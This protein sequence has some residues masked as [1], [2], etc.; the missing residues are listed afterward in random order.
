[1]SDPETK[2]F[3]P[4]ALASISTGIMLMENGFSAIHEAAE[5]LLGH[6][7]WTHELPDCWPRMR[8]CVLEQ[9]PDMP[10]EKPADFRKLA[11]EIKARYGD[12]VE[13]KRG[14]YERS[15]GPIDTFIAQ[16]VD[17]EKII[18]IDSGLKHRGR[19]HDPRD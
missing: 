2:Q 8:K 4:L 17:P 9:F 11:A 19:S 16:G 6:P 14:T 10:V 1:M 3:D 18:A 7:V 15:A 5:W 12:K 13:V